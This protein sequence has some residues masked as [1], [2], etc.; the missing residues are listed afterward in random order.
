MDFT[1]TYESK[2]LVYVAGPYTS[3]D[4]AENTS[5]AI[6]KANEIQDTFPE[7]LCLVPHLTH[8]WHFLS[9]KP[10]EHWIAYDLEVLSRCDALFRMEGESKGADI[11]EEFAI[12][13]DLV[14][15]KS[16]EEVRVWLSL[17]RD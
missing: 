6:W 16:I 12:S 13:S 3:P 1:G 11:E 15:L 14:I 17:M 7:V 8:F 4:P 10:W 9:P 5:N 2:F